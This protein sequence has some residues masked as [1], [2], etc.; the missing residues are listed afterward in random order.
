MDYRKLISDKILSRETA[1]SLVSM[2][3]HEGATIVFSNGCF[4]IIHPGHAQYLA[5]AAA[6]GHKLILGVNTDKSVTKLKG[7][8][9]PIIPEKERC[10]LLA[11]FLFVDAIV[12]FDE[13]TPLGLITLLLP[14]VLVKGKDYTINQIVG[15]D[16][17]LQNGGKV[18]TIELVE[19]F[20]TSKL[21]E[22]IAKLSHK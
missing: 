19:G 13:D 14:D 9:R 10:H 5:E 20:S 18:E 16:I 11:S 1:A 15:A 17:V 8:G 7:K 12:L 4:D 6:L 22:R 3:K 21:I 2:W